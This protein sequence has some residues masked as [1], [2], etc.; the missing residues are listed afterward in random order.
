M[1]WRFGT[2]LVFYFVKFALLVLGYAVSMAASNLLFK[3]TS[4]K[5]GLEWGVW[6]LA[7]NVAG[8][9]CP[10]LITYALREQS[11]QLVYAFTL[12]TGFVLL[13]LVAWWWFKAP[14]TGLQLGGLILTVVGLVMLQL[15][16]V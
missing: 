1:L 10:I 15:G 5:S 2:G 12:G 16:R 8:F 4:T 7:G 9:G 13:Q 11:P 14:V 6:F 3:V